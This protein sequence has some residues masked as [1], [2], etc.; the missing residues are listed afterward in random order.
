MCIRP[1]K[2]LTRLFSDAFLFCK[3]T[4]N[5]QISKCTKS[6]L[7]DKKQ[8]KMSKNSKHKKIVNYWLSIRYILLISIVF[9]ELYRVWVHNATCKYLF[10]G[11]IRFIG[12][13]CRFNRTWIWYSCGKSLCFYDFCVVIYGLWMLLFFYFVS[14]FVCNILRNHC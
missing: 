6:V 13:W 2:S 8:A 3:D 5:F 10:T 9:T 4:K 7:Y 14:I 11:G 1:S 12:T